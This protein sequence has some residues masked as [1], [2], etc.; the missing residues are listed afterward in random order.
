MSAVQTQASSSGRQ[1]GYAPTFEECQ[2]FRS[3]SFFSLAVV[4]QHYPTLNPLRS[5]RARGGSCLH[6][7]NARQSNDGGIQRET[8]MAIAQ[9]ETTQ[10]ETKAKVCL[11][12]TE[13]FFEIVA[14]TRGSAA[15]T[16]TRSL[17]IQQER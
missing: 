17:P 4:G 16:R 9:A 1:R 5:L 8:N 7:S 10:R 12:I 14:R 2:Q 11:R 6:G 13:L 15:A 3:I